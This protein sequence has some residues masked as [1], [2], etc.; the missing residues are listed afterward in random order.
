[1]RN[2]EQLK[3]SVL[4]ILKSIKYPG[5]SRDIVSFG[6]V[7]DVQI[8]DETATIL[9]GMKGIAQATASEIQTQIIE[10]L[11]GE[12]GPRHIEVQWENQPSEQEGHQGGD[13]SGSLL[14]PKPLPGTDKII[15]I[16]SGKGGVGKST[17]A[18][19]LACTAARTGLRV[20]LLDSDIYG[21]SLPTL[22][23]VKRGPVMGKNGPLPIEKHGIAAMSIGFIVERGQPLIWRGPMVNKALEQ[24]LTQ[25]EWGN[26]DILFLDLPPGTGDV[27]LTLAQKYKIDGA[28]VVTTPQNIALEDVQRG[29]IMFRKVN[30]PVLGVVENMSYYRCVHCGHLSH[31]FGAGGG[32]K[33][34][35]LLSLPL[36]GQ[37]PLDP[38]TRELSDAGIPIVISEPESEST[39]SY[40]LLW[41]QTWKALEEVMAV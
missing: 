15:A 25:T 3:K 17:V 4:D 37:I 30:I 34:A 32:K 28:L 14:N 5:Y 21:P 38:R 26:L 22:L 10:K 7:Q 27:Q 11:K 33:E 40:K 6:I 24:L 8:T 9:L 23:G 41:E 1:M 12:F 29:A 18:V 13:E 16:S 2:R 20:G 39:K 35:D 36:L 31:P 19:N